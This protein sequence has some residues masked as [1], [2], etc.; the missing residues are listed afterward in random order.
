MDPLPAEMTVV[1]M[2]IPRLNGLRSAAV[3]QVARAAVATIESRQDDA[4][5]Y[6][7]EVISVGLLLGDD[8]PTLIDNLIGYAIA[9]TGGEALASFYEANGR[10][11]EAEDLL[12][13]RESVER[14]AALTR[15]AVPGS[16]LD[17]LGRMPEIVTDTTFIRGLRWEFFIIVNSV[18]PCVN[19]NRIVFGPDPAYQAWLDEAHASLVRFPS[20]EKL[21]GLFRQGYFGAM[22]ETSSRGIVAR[23]IDIVLGA[24][25]DPGRCSRMLQLLA[26]ERLM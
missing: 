24:S 21:F 23:T 2:P 15:L 18:A 8:G 7:R 14:A 4:E 12:W 16:P 9:K 3:A 1:S 26:A 6:L 20:E 5:H 22:A 19:L 13:A 11:D 10:T 17:A 25:E